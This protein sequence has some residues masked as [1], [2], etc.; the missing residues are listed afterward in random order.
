[1]AVLT[2]MSASSTLC[3]DA[4]DVAVGDTMQSKRLV[5]GLYNCATL[6]SLPAGSLCAPQTA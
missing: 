6:N 5:S 4:C 3:C 1:M 2:W